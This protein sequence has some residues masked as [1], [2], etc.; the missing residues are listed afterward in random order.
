MM[1]LASM[2]LMPSALGEQVSEGVPSE[3]L[4]KVAH[5][6]ASDGLDALQIVLVVALLGAAFL[7]A[8]KVLPGRGRGLHFLDA[9]LT[10]GSAPAFPRKAEK[11]IRNDFFAGNLQAVLERW[12][13]ASCAPCSLEVLR[14]VAQSA[15]TLEALEEVARYA[16]RFP[17]ALDPSAAH[18]LLLR[19]L[20]SVSPQS[21]RQGDALFR[22]ILNAKPTEHTYEQLL[23]GYAAAT[24][25]TALRL[26]V[27]DLPGQYV[28]VAWR[29]NV[30]FAMSRAFVR[31]GDLQGGVAVVE[32]LEGRADE[33]EGAPMPA[34]FRADFLAALLSGL[35]RTKRTE[36]GLELFVTRRA[37]L[38]KAKLD[39]L[40]YSQLIKAHCDAREM[41]GA[42][43]LF[44]E[45]LQ[46]GCHPDAHVFTHLIDGCCRIANP[47]LAEKLFH[48][49]RAAGNAPTIYAIVALVKVYGRCGLCQKAKD[50][51][52][53][54][55]EAF[56]VAPTVVVYT[57]LISS[58]VRQKKM[59]PAYVVFCKMEEALVPDAKATETLVQGLAE[60]EMFP[61]LEQVLRR[62]AQRGI[63]VEVP[64]TRR[65]LSRGKHS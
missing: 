48:D 45:M 51:V 2:F 10:S 38:A 63:R 29:T 3:F 57:C 50:L 4:G 46:S 34:T 47:D 62:S 53:S 30:A 6:M 25:T 40:T 18:T 11:A 37:D 16:A 49:M 8:D 23:L 56:G 42:L 61:E 59:R 17:D 60:A 27:V 5:V 39:M 20:V 26:A 14:M 65:G 43:D 41:E 52:D 13:E 32:A 12:R 19:A 35:L 64:R 15:P 22:Q 54:M 28:H 1:L 58:L 36:L 44:E 21:T 7:L 9:A 24:H 31:Q 33:C 55:E